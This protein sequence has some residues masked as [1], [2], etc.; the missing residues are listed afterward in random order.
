M[1]KLKDR[2]QWIREYEVWRR[3]PRT[4]FS[5]WL[6]NIAQRIRT[7]QPDVLEDA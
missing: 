3:S 7:K 2:E 1:K 4:R 5:F 6:E